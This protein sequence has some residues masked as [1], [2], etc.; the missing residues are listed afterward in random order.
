MRVSLLTL[1]LSLSL[2]PSYLSFCPSHLFM[3]DFLCVLFLFAISFSSPLLS[4]CFILSYLLHEYS[5]QRSTH[6]HTHTDTHTH[7]HTVRVLINHIHTHTHTHSH[8][9]THT[10]TYKA[11][12]VGRESS[13]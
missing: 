13:C 8:T 12:R 5:L 7:R 3:F 1:S 6:T 10:Q 11:Q 9:H 2:S 4:S